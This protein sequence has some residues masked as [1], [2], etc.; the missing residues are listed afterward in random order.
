VPAVAR[1]LSLF[2][3]SIFTELAAI[4]VS[5]R[6]NAHAG[7]VRTLFLVLRCHDNLLMIFESRMV[8]Q[9]YEA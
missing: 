5:S 9:S 2:A 6:R 3:P 1:D 8:V 4:L 7:K